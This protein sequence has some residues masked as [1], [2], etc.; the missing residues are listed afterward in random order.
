MPAL[1][2]DGAAVSGQFSGVGNPQWFEFTPQAGQDIL[3]SL[4]LADNAGAAELYIGQGYMPSPLDY[5]A[6]ES[7]WNSPNVTALAASTSGQPYYVLAEP[8]S[9]SGATS[10]FTIQAAALDFPI[11]LGLARHRR[12]CR[13]GDPRIARR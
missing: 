7:Q 4:N 1:P 8:T 10:A 12:Q 9:L 6:K 2:I 11:E 5:D 13:L 3:V